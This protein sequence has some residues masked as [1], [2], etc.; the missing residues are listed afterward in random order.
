MEDHHHPLL[1]IQLLKLD[2]Q[3]LKLPLLLLPKLVE[4]ACSEVSVQLLWL[5]WLSEL[6]LKSL[7]KLLEELLVEEV[8]LSKKIHKNL[9]DL[10]KTIL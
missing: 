6:V 1:E 8:Y 10:N 4:E 3:C 7:I 9:F 5:V 2:L